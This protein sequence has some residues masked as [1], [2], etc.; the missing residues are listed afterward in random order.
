MIAKKL[1]GRLFADRGYIFPRLFADLFEDGIHSVT[2]IKADM[3]NSP[4]P[5][6]DKIMPTEAFRY[7]VHP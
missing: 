6:W 2:G 1:Y 5:F 3:K 4:M 7:R